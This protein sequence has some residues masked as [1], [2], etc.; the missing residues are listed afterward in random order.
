MRNLPKLCVVIKNNQRKKS[1]ANLFFS[2]HI[3]TASAHVFTD[4]MSR[5]N[6]IAIK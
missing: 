5:V 4:F 3:M 1:A 6:L 2:L